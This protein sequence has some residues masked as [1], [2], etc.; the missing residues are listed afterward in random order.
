MT[1]VRSIDRMARLSRRFQAQGKRIGVVPTMGALHEGHLSL[2]R[3]A[4]AQNDVVIVTVFVNPL[5][6]GP[7]EDLARYPR[8]LRRDVKRSREAGADVVFA[9]SVE[10]LYP[11]RFQTTVQVG[12]L[13]ERWEGQVRPG[14]FRGVATVVTILFQV[15]RPTRA[16]VGQKDYQQSLIVRRLVRDLRLPVT[17]HVLP[18]VREP[19]GLAMSSRNVSLSAPRRRR[20]AVLSRV[21]QEARRRIRAGERRAA[22]VLAAM[23]TRLRREAL[24]RI[25]Y[26][27]IVAA[28]T[29]EPQARLHGRVAILVAARLGRTRLVDN[30]LVDVP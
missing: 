21:L 26:V 22:P 9:P 11:P 13:A 5:Q 25:D 28:D 17:I 30:V 8:T 29:L 16:Y 12:P 10:A 24:A 6:F 23:R 1:V 4:A 3:R 2:I 18:T 14:H 20:A 7:H 27:A 15:T 19:D